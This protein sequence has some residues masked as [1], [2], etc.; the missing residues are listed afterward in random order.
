MVTGAITGLVLNLD[1]EKTDKNNIVQH[2]RVLITL[3]QTALFLFQCKAMLSINFEANTQFFSPL[4]GERV[5]GS[6][7]FRAPLNLFLRQRKHL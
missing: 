3:S 4:N 1:N 5:L 2:T 6:A 7:F